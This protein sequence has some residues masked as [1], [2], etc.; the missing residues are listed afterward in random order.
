MK[1]NIIAAISIA[2]TACSLNHRENGW[3]PVDDANIIEGE[4]IATT[5]DFEV[6]S[7]D[8]ITTPGVAFIEG[9]LKQNKVDS[10]TDATERRIGKRIGFVFNDSVIMAPTVNCTIES[11]SFTINSPDKELI[12]EIYNSLDCEKT[13]VPYNISQKSY[14]TAG[15]MTMK[16]V[17]PDPITVLV[18]SIVLE[19]INRRDVDLTTGEWYRIDR[20]LSENWE[21]APYSAK[22]LELMAKGTEVCFN[23]IGYVVRPNGT[24]N[25]TIKPWIY[26][27][28]DKSAIY[29]LVKTFHY[30]PYPIQ[31]SDT[32]YVEFQIK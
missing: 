1:C 21:Q 24:F 7:L 4:A 15:G 22:Y 31:K 20:K 3:Y 19:F 6:V 29:R 10:W 26:D 30:P 13:E 28:S 18:D 17:S 32:V 9:K 23:D 2:L 14:A 16:I 11:G 27:L 5:A 25:M 12:L 8:T